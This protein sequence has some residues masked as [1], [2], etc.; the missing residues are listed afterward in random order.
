M[1]KDEAFRLED[2]S[3]MVLVYSQNKSI[4]FSFFRLAK[5]FTKLPSGRKLEFPF[6][7]F[8]PI[9]EGMPRHEFHGL[10]ISHP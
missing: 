5:Y 1:Q 3:L 6:T 7:R 8:G 4:L 9:R 10:C 2:T